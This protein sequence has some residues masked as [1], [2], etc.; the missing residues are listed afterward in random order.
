MSRRSMRFVV[1]DG[2]VFFAS[3]T[4]L[5]VV[6]QLFANRSTNRHLHKANPEH[7]IVNFSTG[8][9]TSAPRNHLAE[10]HLAVWVDAC[11]ELKIPITAKGTQDIILQYRQQ[12]GQSPPLTSQPEEARRDEF[13]NEA[14]INA[15]IEWIV[16]DDQVCDC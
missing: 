12:K 10:T 15:I 9:S 13:S 6:S 4:S 3:K 2:I 5:C 14:F 8:T 1:A 11:D 7:N 16:A